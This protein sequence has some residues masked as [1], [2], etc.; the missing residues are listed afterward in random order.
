MA[1]KVQARPDELVSRRAAQEWGVLSLAELAEC[2]LS[3][4]LVRIRVE[5][6]WLHPGM[7]VIPR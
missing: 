2:D 6:G 4:N 3:R 1:N 5:K 7:G